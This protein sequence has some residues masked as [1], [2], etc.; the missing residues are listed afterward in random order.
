MYPYQKM[1]KDNELDKILGDSDITSCTDA[2][3]LGVVHQ[4]AVIRALGIG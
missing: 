4:F 1:M 3:T 2:H